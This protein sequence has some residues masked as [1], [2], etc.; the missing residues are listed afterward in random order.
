MSKLAFESHQSGSCVEVCR[1]VWSCV[2]DGMELCGG[3]WK[4]EWREE[5]A[6]VSRLGVSGIS[7]GGSRCEPLAAQQVDGWIGAVSGGNNG[8]S[9]CT[10]SLLSFC[11]LCFLFLAQ[12][13]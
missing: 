13:F 6:E 5:H 7:S 3:V 2:E 1:G 4:M 10:A 12:F 8:K 11:P 9:L